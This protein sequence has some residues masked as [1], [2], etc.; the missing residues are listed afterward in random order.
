MIDKSLPISD[1]SFVLQKSNVLRGPSREKFKA[2]VLK[3][4]VY[5]GQIKNGKRHGV[6]RLCHITDGM[7]EGEFKN[8]LFH[9]F[10]R[11][12]FNNYVFYEGQWQQG[13]KHGMGTN[14]YQDGSQELAQW[15]MDK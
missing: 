14:H 5:V 2:N 8:G 13:K 15:D 12:L 11:F 1:L 6:G 4:D 9:G 7:Y 10:G 3:E